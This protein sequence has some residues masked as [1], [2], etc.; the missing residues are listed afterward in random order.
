MATPNVPGLLRKCAFLLLPLLTQ[1]VWAHRL[2]PIVTEFAQPL[3]PGQT[4][5]EVTYEYAREP[6]GTG[7]EQT[8]PEVELERGLTRWMQ[9]QVGMPLVRLKD[10]G[11][12]TTLAGG[13]LEVGLR[14]L[15]AGGRNRSWAVSLNPSVELP[16]GNRRQFGRGTDVGASFHF[17]KFFAGNWRWHTN[18]G[19]ASTVS[20]EEAGQ[21][22]LRS[23]TAVVIPITRRWYL[24]PE[25]IG[26]R[27]FVNAR[28][29][30]AAQPAFIFYVNRH[31]EL[32]FAL[33]VG[34]TE[35]TPRLGVRSQ[36]AFIWGGAD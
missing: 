18:L 36:I 28:T 27:R 8:I 5:V 25:I 26:A 9:F 16:T 29:E 24:A 6:E 12:P 30:M 7:S 33:P 19:L 2:E 14:L 11:K 3:Q 17:D 15:L 35:A 34:L 32:K 21:K 10:D 4:N 31:L 23:S 20:G 22:L 13:H 1:Q